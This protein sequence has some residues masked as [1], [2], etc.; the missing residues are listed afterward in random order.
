[1]ARPIEFD[2]DKLYVDE[3]VR[4]VL[5][6]REHLT[7]GSELKLKSTRLLKGYL[8][9]DRVIRDVFM[10]ETIPEVARKSYSEFLRKIA[11][12][13]DNGSYPLS[14]LDLDRIA[15]PT[16]TE[17]EQLESIRKTAHIPLAS[18]RRNQK[19]ASRGE[20]QKRHRK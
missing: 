13:I 16:K 12:Q 11:D 17:S 10:H 7:D 8:A 5:I 2:Q 15:T 6:L 9:S 20:Q 4:N 19:V 18:G 3:T 1:M 14:R